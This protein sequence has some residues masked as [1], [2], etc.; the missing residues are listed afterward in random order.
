[1]AE[2]QK[3]EEEYFLEN[4]EDEEEDVEEGLY[5]EEEEKEEVGGPGNEAGGSRISHA[6]SII[7]L[8]WQW[9]QS[10]KYVTMFVDMSLYRN[11]HSSPL[12]IWV[13]FN[14]FVC[15]VLYSA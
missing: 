9:P 1:M 3:E 2:N 8:Q 10:Y 13:Y 6:S 7:S 5:L 4:G 14:H 15:M 11:V 12:F